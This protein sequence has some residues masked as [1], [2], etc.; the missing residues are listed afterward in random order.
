MSD[1][2]LVQEVEDLI[3]TMP[4]AGTITH[5][6][7]AILIWKGRLAA[8]FNGLGSFPL[9]LRVQQALAEID[10]G[11]GDQSA[12]G[13]RNLISL[14][15]EARHTLRMRSPTATS[16]LVTK[17]AIFEYFDEVRKIITTATSGV[18]FIDPFANPD[19]VA[20][21]LPHI[22]PAIAIRIL[23]KEF[24][25]QNIPALVSSVDAF[26]KQNG[27]N[28]QVKSS[29]G[30][31]DRYVFLDQRECYQS[32]ASFK[33]GAKNAP[34]GIV[35]IIDAFPAMLST[36]EGIWNSAKVER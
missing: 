31:H 7:D 32:G 24:D 3:R 6:D 29:P 15:H 8:V 13:A 18:F 2:F 33:D 16:T 28:I 20:R 26:A 17:G 19:F 36:Y 5:F 34:A 9:S 30:I 12:K 4:A 14:L 11:R 25:K 35:Q 22:S 23:A 10:S 1:A 21:Y 27:H